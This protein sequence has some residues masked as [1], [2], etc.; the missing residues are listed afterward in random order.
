[1]IEIIAILSC[2]CGIALAIAVQAKADAMIRSNPHLHV[3]AID[4]EPGHKESNIC[5]CKPVRIPGNMTFH[6]DIENADRAGHEI[7]KALNHK[8]DPTPDPGP[9]KPFGRFE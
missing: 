5:P 3:G 7:A 9:G 2:I 6:N 4:R 1:M 8:P